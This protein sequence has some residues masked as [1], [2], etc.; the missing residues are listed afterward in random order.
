MNHVSAEFG[1]AVF[2]ERRKEGASGEE[3]REG[4]SCDAGGQ[5]P[6]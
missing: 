6:V 5:N 4:A 2:A 3:G 1:G